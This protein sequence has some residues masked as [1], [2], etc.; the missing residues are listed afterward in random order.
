[1]TFDNA[2]ELAAVFREIAAQLVADYHPD[3]LSMG[4]RLDYVALLN[5]REKALVKGSKYAP[6][7]E[8]AVTGN[9]SD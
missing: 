3:G 2:L 9:L 6:K 7:P 5:P 4:R 1:M 8:S